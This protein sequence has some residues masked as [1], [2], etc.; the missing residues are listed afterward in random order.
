MPVFLGLDCGGS[1]CR[2]IAVDEAGAVLHAG[3][4]GP[5][6]LAS[7]P[8]KRLEANVR[9]ACDGA[10]R[11]DYVA[12]CFAGLLIESDRERAL[13]LLRSIAPHAQIRAEP[14]YVAALMAC[15]PPPDLCIVGGTGSLVCSRHEGGVVRSG[16]GGY[17]LGDVGSACQ[18]GRAVVRHFLAAGAKGLSDATLAALEKQFGSAVENEV[19]AALY[20]GGAPA[21]R[22]A[23]FAPALARDAQAGE[24]YAQQAMR[25]QTAELAAIVRN[26]YDRYHNSKRN[27]SICLAGGL[28]DASPIFQSQLEAA[29]CGAFSEVELSLCRI[30]RAPVHGAVRLARELAS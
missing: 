11:P 10:P 15:E 9:K 24:P 6:N 26:H 29:L 13:A 8:P 28:W 22:L 18:Y 17:L 23:K 4:G 21:A 16:G 3:Q 19:L 25:E 14:D 1:S 5:A 12:G 2:A 20:R 27:I 7:T 30:A